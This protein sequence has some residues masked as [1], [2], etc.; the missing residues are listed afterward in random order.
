MVMLSVVKLRWNKHGVSLV[1]MQH[2]L[3]R[4]HIFYFATETETDE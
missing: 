4:Y 3:K 1:E 2:F